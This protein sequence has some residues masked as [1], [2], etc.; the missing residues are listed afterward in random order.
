[1]AKK[2]TKKEPEEIEIDELE[3]DEL[4]EEELEALEELEDEDEEEDLEEDF[5]ED[6]EDNRLEGI[7]ERMDKRTEIMIDYIKE[8]AQYIGMA[9]AIFNMILKE[10]EIDDFTKDYI[11]NWIFDVDKYY[12]KRSQ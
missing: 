8:T 3:E 11:K 6:K 7:L 12:N 10:Q 5:E 2:K 9:K 1:M 4:D